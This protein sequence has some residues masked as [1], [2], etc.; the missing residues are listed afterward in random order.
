MIISFRKYKIEVNQL[1]NNFKVYLKT[2]T[3][4]MKRVIILLG[5]SVLLTTC[6]EEESSPKYIWEG[7]NVK[8]TAY[9]SVS[10][11]TEGDP[12]LTAF[13][14]TLK[15]GMKSIAVSRDLYRMGLKHNTPV[16]IEGLEG[17]YLVKDRMHPR[18]T[19]QIDIYMGTDVQ[20]ARQWGRK[21]VCID[22]GTPIMTE[23]E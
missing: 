4:K 9:N 14:D 23:E 15:P 6:K 21:R 11:Q 13:G 20:A 12:N 7:I 22:F 3:Y 5:I 10:W 2:E 17:I 16:K 1:E 19:R 8:A 18:K